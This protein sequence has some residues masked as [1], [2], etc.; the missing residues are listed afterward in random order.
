MSSEQSQLQQMKPYL[1]V[2]VVLFIILL[3]VMFWPSPKTPEP[4]VQPQPV[5]SAVETEPATPIADNYNDNGDTGITDMVSPDVFQPPKNVEEVALDGNNQIEEFEA[6]EIPVEVPIDISDAS[7]KSAL[8]AVAKSPTFGRLLVNESLI[9]KFVINVHNLADEELASK[10]S[11]VVAPQD[12]FKTYQQADR[13]WIDKA[14]FSR[15][16]TYVDALESIEV[17]ELLSVY[18]TYKSSIVEKYA[19]ISRPG[20]NFDRTLIQAIDELLD[21]PQV[22]MPI[23]VFSESVMYKFKDARLENLSAPQKQL[24][25]TGPEN[26]RRIKAIL[27]D[28]KS[29]LQAR[30]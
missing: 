17:D 10:D 22:P 23:E 3:A 9:Q 21:T 2:A 7:V 5:S 18:D 12:S 14:S 20:A 19:E 28:L 6:E 25:R 24:L 1:I 26:M 11:L 27:R 30:S 8:L 16:N 29:E 13:T 4:V 15:Y